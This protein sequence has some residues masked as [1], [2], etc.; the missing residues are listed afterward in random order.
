M[1]EAKHRERLSIDT[2]LVSQYSACSDICLPWQGTTA[3]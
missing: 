1:G 2:V 3:V